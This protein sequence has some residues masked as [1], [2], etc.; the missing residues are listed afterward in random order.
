MK[1]PAR[2]LGC[3]R[4]FRFLRER[5]AA[6]GAECHAGHQEVRLPIS[7]LLARIRMLIPRQKDGHYEEIV[8]G[9][10]NGTLRA[11]VTPMSDRELGKASEFL[12]DAPSTEAVSDLDRQ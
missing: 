8:R 1:D 5:V 10:G 2:I 12:K 9:F 7:A 3:R 4:G 6:I 11:P